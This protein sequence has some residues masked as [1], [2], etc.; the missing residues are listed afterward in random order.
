[1]SDSRVPGLLG[2]AMTMIDRM[3]P[4]HTCVS[5]EDEDSSSCFNQGEILSSNH[6]LSCLLPLWN[7]Q[8]CFQKE[9]NLRDE[10]PQRG[11]QGL[12]GMGK[13]FSPIMAAR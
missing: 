5:I 12:Y 8:S 9:G 10:R 7:R 2:K 6:A 11:M 13:G 1:M 3:S 4:E